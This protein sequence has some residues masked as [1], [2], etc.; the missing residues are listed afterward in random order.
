MLKGAFIRAH[1]VE[2]EA[3]IWHELHFPSAFLF[4]QL[5]ASVSLTAFIVSVLA[6]VLHEIYCSLLLCPSHLVTEVC[7]CV[8]V[9]LPPPCIIYPPKYTRPL[10]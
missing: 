8:C 9:H 2:E 1:V 7:V 6:H 5:R 4:P 10:K 3:K